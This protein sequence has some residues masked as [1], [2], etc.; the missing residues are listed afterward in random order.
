MI[1]SLSRF[2]VELTTEQATLLFERYD[3]LARGTINMVALV[4]DIDPYETF[5]TA[6]SGGTASR[7][8]PTSARC[9]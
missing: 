4:R 8:T 1:Q 9:R 3:T 2:G 7:R 6:S 5:S